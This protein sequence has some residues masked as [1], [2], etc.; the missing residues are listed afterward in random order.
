MLQAYREQHMQRI[1]RDEMRAGDVVLVAWQQGP[2]QH[3][4]IV[5]NHEYGCLG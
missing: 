3:L 1:A 2:P 4:G 5:Y